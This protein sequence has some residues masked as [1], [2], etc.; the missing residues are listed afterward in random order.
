MTIPIKSKFLSEDINFNKS[1]TVMNLM[2]K[3][4]I[5]LIFF[6]SISISTASSARVYVYPATVTGQVGK[7]V[8]IE[9]RAE[10]VNNMAAWQTRIDFNPSVLSY[11]GFIE[12]PLLKNN[13]GTISGNRSYA[14]SVAVFSSFSNPKSSS[15]VSGSG[16][17]AYVDFYVKNKGSCS[18]NI[19]N[20]KTYLLDMNGNEVIVSKSNGYFSSAA[21]TTVPS[22]GGGART[23]TYALN[24]SD[25]T[26]IAV[27]SAVAIIVVI[28]SFFRFF[29]RRR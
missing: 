28:F 6:F 5:I 22:G 17:L 29:A 13:G 16:T 1:K 24:I 8:R 23:R 26:L 21:V 12:G 18:L 15:S 2:K 11:S 3:L 9:L 4:A 10:S 19:A 14:G 7:T 27:I 20:D 25:L